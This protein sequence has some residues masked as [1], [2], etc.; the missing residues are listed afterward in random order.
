M[1]LELLRFKY[2]L[3]LLFISQVYK[4]KQRVGL[5]EK[6]HASECII[7]SNINYKVTDK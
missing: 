3:S 7:Y 1:L 2:H 6:L 4:K 5:L